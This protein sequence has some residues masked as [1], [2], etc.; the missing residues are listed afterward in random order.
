MPKALIIHGHFYQPP[1]ENPW[2]GEVDAEPSAAPFHDWNERIHAECYAPNIVNYPLISFNFGPTLLSWLESSSPRYLPENLNR[3]SR[4]RCGARGSRQ[5]DRTGLRP[6]HSS[7]LQ[8]TRSSDTSSFGAS[9][10]FVI[11]SAVKRKH[12]GYPRLPRTIRCSRYS[13][14][15][16]CVT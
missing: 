9:P 12:S 1:R 13:L 7:T 3:R 14:N 6:R 15:R 10:T 16:A 11:V 2:N 8:R 5:C 4:E